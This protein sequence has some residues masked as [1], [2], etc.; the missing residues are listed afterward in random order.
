MK[1][2]LLI[3]MFAPASALVAAVIGT[4][5]SNRW[6]RRGSGPNGLS[7]S[8]PETTSVERRSLHGTV[9]TFIAV[10]IVGFG[11]SKR[12]E[13]I[14]L[15]VR[16][17]MYQI[18]QEAFNE[19][20]RQIPQEAFRKGTSWDK[21]LHE[22]R[23]DGVIILVPPE[24]PPGRVIALFPAYLAAGLRRHN[25]TA[26]EPA[27]IR[28][29]VAMHTGVVLFDAKGFYG[30]AVI[31]VCR[32]LDAP[33]FKDAL[34]TSTD[35][36]GLLVSDY[37]YNTVIRHGHDLINPELYHALNVTSKETQCRAWIHFPAGSA[38][39]FVTIEPPASARDRRG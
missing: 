20:M 1:L 30:D 4:V 10:D 6:L 8:S 32:L 23:G 37:L 38:G 14:Q 35:D 39:T 12:D 11:N 24:F 21:C 28:L 2:E 29:R 25:K 9:S 7:G 19:S 15:S 31:H 33:V 5:V 3:L 26:S 27:E 36:L 13:H 16:S 22:D 18:L 17:S 34:A